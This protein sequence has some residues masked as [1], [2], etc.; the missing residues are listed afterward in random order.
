MNLFTRPVSAALVAATCVLAASACGSGSG[1][2]AGVSRPN[3]ASTL[4]RP[5]PP[6]PLGPLAPSATSGAS[7]TLTAADV[8]DDGLP[9]KVGPGKLSTPTIKK[10]TQYFEDRVAR[11]YATGNA[12]ALAHYL[13]GPMLSGNRATIA[14]LNGKQ[15]LNVFRL[16]VESVKPQTNEAHHLIINL[17]ADMVLDYFVST[18]THKVIDNGLPGPSQVQFVIF[19]DQNPKTHTWYWTGEQ[20]AAAASS[21]SGSGATVL[22]SG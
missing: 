13:A 16:K 9:S 7:P 10:L 3:P 22:G 21:G 17:T 5:A 12:D 19:L 14:L 15:R 6:A 1:S 2:V 8:A 4:A 11:A 18:T 20:S